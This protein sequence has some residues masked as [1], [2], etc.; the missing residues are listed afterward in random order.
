V[1]TFRGSETFC[2]YCGA[3][4]DSA[5]QAAG[6][7]AFPVAGMWSLCFSCGG[8]GVFT[9]EGLAVRRVTAAEEL[10][11]ATNHDLQQAIRTWLA[12]RASERD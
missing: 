4:N 7:D 2:P 5:T 12:F 6:E 9:G 3:A 11:A 10:A 8:I 1:R